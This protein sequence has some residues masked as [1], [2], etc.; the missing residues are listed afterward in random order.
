MPVYAQSCMLCV[1]VCVYVCALCRVRLYMRVVHVCVC[2]AC[3][4][5]CA[6]EQVTLWKQFFKVPYSGRLTILTELDKNNNGI[7]QGKDGGSACLFLT[8]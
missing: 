7:I 3:E 6:Q 2:G 4:H 8:L 1:C 5:T